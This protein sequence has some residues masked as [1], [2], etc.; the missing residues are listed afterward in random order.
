M[1]MLS[2]FSDYDV[3]WPGATKSALAWFDG[4]NVG[5][6]MI[7]PGATQLGGGGADGEPAQSRHHTCLELGAFPLCP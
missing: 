4:I 7:A 3:A 6:S 2:L 1:Q 5:F